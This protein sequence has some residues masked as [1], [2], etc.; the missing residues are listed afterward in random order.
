MFDEEEGLGDGTEETPE[1]AVDSSREV[2]ETPP[3]TDL[4][5]R[6]QSAGLDLE[7]VDPE[8]LAKAHALHSRIGDSRVYTDN[9]LPGVVHS[10]IARLSQTAEGR[11]YLR[12]VSGGSENGG[13][14]EESD[15]TPVSPV[16]ARQ[17][18][19]MQRKI[20]ELDQVRG[21]FVAQQE[22]QR[23]GQQIE[24]ALKGAV[25]RVPGARSHTLLE[26]DFW[27]EVAAGAV[28]DRS[29][30]PTGISAWVKSYVAQRSSFAPKPKAGVSVGSRRGSSGSNKKVDEMTADDV[31][32]ILSEQMGLPD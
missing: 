7:N 15:D 20:A 31:T 24:S 4:V 2:G 1:P 30:T 18:A 10:Q 8:A 3:H 14:D 19:E 25:S 26:R 9:D 32:A 29:M 17:L 6:F 16:V 22:S 28:P 11:A 27:T 12:R 21:Q 13:S 23:L 5:S